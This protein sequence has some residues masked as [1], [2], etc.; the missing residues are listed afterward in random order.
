MKKMCYVYKVEFCAVRKENE[1]R[2]V[3]EKWT[4]L[5]VITLSDTNQAQK[6]KYYVFFQ[7]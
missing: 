4:C 3:A 1:I 5:N 7:M 2:I 6:D